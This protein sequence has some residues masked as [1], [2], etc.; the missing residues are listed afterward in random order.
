DITHRVPFDEVAKKVASGSILSLVPNSIMEQASFEE[1]N[2]YFRA[3]SRA[4]VARLDG[5]LALYVMPCGEDILALKDSLYALGPHIPRAGC[6]IGLIA[7]GTAAVNAAPATAAPVGT[8]TA[9]KP[10]KQL[11]SGCCHVNFA[12]ACPAFRLQTRSQS[13]AVHKQQQSSEVYLAIGKG[14]YGFSVD[15]ALVSHLWSYE[16]FAEDT[17]VVVEGSHGFLAVSSGR[18]IHILDANSPAK[19]RVSWPD[20]HQ[21]T[22]YSMHFNYETGIIFS[23]GKD[24]C[25][26][27]WEIDGEELSLYGSC[28]E[29]HRDF[30]VALQFHS[31]SRLLISAG[32]DGLV[33]A[34]RIASTG[35]FALLAT[36]ADAHPDGITALCTNMAQNVMVSSGRDGNL[37]LWSYRPGRLRLIDSQVDVHAGW[38]RCLEFDEASGL[39]VSA[40][41]DGAIKAFGFKDG[42]FNCRISAANAH[43]AGILALQL[44]AKTMCLLSAD[45]NGAIKMWELSAGAGELVLKASIEKA[46]DG[47]A[48]SHMQF[49]SQRKLLL[50]AGS[51][52]CL[53]AWLWHPD[54]LQAVASA[55]AE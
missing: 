49:C 24:C 50:S 38:A 8:A 47:G 44:C 32:L 4:G 34:W 5:S 11:E 29:A 17:R 12:V 23:S 53:R 2:K 51:D 14:C 52:N 10:P 27:A 43:D 6:L 37:R 16:G 41:D 22:I 25:V 13:Q 21:D 54:G 18:S 20:A 15:T 30:V 9:S 42:K 33:R 39:V 26:K 3:K 55:A 19:P 1:Y 36:S 40:G 35:A 46:H 7:P 31:S 28:P 48:V 45:E